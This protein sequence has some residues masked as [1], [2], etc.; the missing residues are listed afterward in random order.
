MAKAE[1]NSK[2]KKKNGESAGEMFLDY[3]LGRTLYNNSN[4]SFLHA[5]LFCNKLI[6]ELDVA[7]A[8]AKKF[9]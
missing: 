3:L 7:I 9:E 6:R 5:L 1:E 2:S 8:K 4:T